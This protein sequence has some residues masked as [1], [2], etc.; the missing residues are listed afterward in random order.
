MPEDC[1]LVSCQRMR[2]PHHE[3][4]HFAGKG[5]SM[6]CISPMPAKGKCWQCGSYEER[7][8]A[9]SDVHR[10]DTLRAAAQAVVDATPS[11]LAAAKD[12]LKRVL[13]AHPR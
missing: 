9:S 2:R 12:E 8:M 11:D 6:E 7:V 3:G 4:T 5:D 10:F 13:E 1:Q